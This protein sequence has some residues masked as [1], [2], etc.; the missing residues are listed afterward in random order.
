M[1]GGRA[2]VDGDHARHLGA[3]GWTGRHGTDA[4]R[5]MEELTAAK[6]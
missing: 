5:T 6:L 2:I 1:V 3:T 4:V